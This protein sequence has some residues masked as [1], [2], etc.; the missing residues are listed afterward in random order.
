LPL[1]REPDATLI[2]ICRATAAVDQFY[3]GILVRWSCYARCF[4]ISRL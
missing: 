2:D 4:E 1:L 3:G